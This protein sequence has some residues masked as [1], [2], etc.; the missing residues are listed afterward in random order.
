M[1]TR[2][3]PICTLVASLG[4]G[5][6]AT[7][8]EEQAR[9]EVAR[10]VSSEL[11]N[12][13]DAVAA[14]QAAAPMPRADGW[15]VPE[16]AMAIDAMK[17]AWKRTRSAYERVEG[18]IAVLFSEIDSSFDNRYTVFLDEN[19]ADADLFDGENV[20]GNHA[21]ERILWSAEISPAVIE[22]ESQHAGYQPARFPMNAAEATGFRDGLVG[23]MRSDAETMRDQFATALVL[24]DAAAFRGVIGSMAEQLEK[25]RLAS[26]SQEES[27]YARYTLTDMRENLVGARATL[28][29]FRA[30]IEAEGGAQ[31]VAQITSRLDA[32]RAAYDA[33][34]GD[35]I[36]EVPEGFD[37]IVPSTEHL[38]TPYGQLYALLTE[39][40]DPEREGSAVALMNQAADLL[41]IP[42]LAR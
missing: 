22:F 7:S 9:V 31:L 3:F 12:L 10:F 21:V 1:K 16:D 34:P 18:A 36:P 35:G 5:A 38:M 37:P 23:R 30:W 25:V 26:T 41:R 17:A 27:R 11:G 8:P 33:I 4:A 20:T 15:R 32:I 6:C 24:D 42:Q 29:A 28:A 14:L 40:S 2:L 39:E 19:G 13:V